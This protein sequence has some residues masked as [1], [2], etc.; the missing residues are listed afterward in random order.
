MPW[1]GAGIRLC[2]P[3]TL[4]QIASLSVCSGASDPVPHHELVGA[5]VDKYGAKRSKA[6]VSAL[7][8]RRRSMSASTC[9]GSRPT[10][11][12]RLERPARRLRAH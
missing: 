2:A 11:L 7:M 9:G 1:R 4:R 10:T 6:G 8:S 5:L 3:F 12:A